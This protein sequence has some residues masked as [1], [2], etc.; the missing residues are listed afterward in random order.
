M[1]SGKEQNTTWPENPL[2]HLWNTCKSAGP[3]Q[4][5]GPYNGMEEGKAGTPTRMNHDLVGDDLR[6]PCLS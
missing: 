2:Y 6:L 3:P 4:G 1:T 5:D